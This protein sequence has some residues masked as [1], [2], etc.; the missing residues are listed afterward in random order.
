MI[1]IFDIKQIR[2][3]DAQTIEE[4]DITSLDLMDRAA[5]AVTDAIAA[6]WTTATNIVIF[7]G[8]GNNG[9]DALAVARLLEARGYNVE[10]YLFNTTGKLSP[11]CTE[12]KHRLAKCPNVKFT[13]VASSFEPPRLTKGMVVID[14]LFGTGLNKPLT[15][16]FAVLARLMTESEASV[17]SIDVPSGLP[18]DTTH[19]DASSVIVRA[20]LTLTFQLPKFPMM[21]ADTACYFGEAEVLDIGLSPTCIRKM[22]TDYV[23]LEAGDLRPL[24]Q[25][26]DPFGHKGTFGH[27]LLIAGKYGMAGAAILNA[28]ACLRSGV[29]KVTLH[30]PEMNNAILQ[31]AVPEAIMSH[32]ASDT[33]FTTPESD[34]PYDAVAIGSGIGTATDTASAFFK[35]I[36]QTTKPL[37]IDADGL[38]ILADHV[39]RLAS[40]PPKTI[41]TPHVAELH[42]LTRNKASLATTLT[43]ARTMAITHN[44][45]VVLKGHHTAICT[46]E[47][48]VYF[49]S[50]GNSGMA[51]AGSGDVL[52]GTLAALLAQGYAPLEACLLGVYLHG[53]AGDLAAEQLSE[54]G[55]VATDIIR[56]LPSAFRVLRGTVD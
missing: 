47:G 41:L 46:P 33:A 37:V 56:Y 51:T 34:A 12:N 11:D 54:E 44:L 19:I 24:L 20:N 9:G 4:E 16:G 8:P 52:T 27:A 25:P 55:L 29:G 14:G 42:R 31:M 39:N 6:R 7:A 22:E 38:N 3:L 15:G 40:L 5:Q 50:T 49:N 35:Q 45:Y 18:C 13:E 23:L 48:K 30:S 1:K 36:G 32:D 10:A 21:L 43:D 26:R 28:K 17:V 53:L 2:D